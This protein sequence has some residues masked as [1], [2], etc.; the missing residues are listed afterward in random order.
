MAGLIYRTAIAIQIM[1][2][3]FMQAILKRFGQWLHI[4]CVDPVQ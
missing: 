3:G 1:N 4:F 2:D